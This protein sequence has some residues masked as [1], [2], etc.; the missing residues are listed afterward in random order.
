MLRSAFWLYASGF[1]ETV[2]RSDLAGAL[3]P[4]YGLIRS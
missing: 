4:A 1:I 3:D 2:G